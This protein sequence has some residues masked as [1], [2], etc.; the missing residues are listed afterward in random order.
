MK[1]LRVLG[2][3]E[4]IKQKFWQEASGGRLLFRKVSRPYAVL[5][6]LLSPLLGHVDVILFRYLNDRKR[7]ISSF[8]RLVADLAVL[9]SARSR[10]IKVYWM[11]HNVDCESKVF[12]PR[13]SRWRRIILGYFSTNIFVTEDGLIESAIELLPYA[14]DK[15]ISACTFGLIDEV[16]RKPKRKKIVDDNLGCVPIGK[17]H[18]FVSLNN[19]SPKKLREV[20][21]LLELAEKAADFSS[22]HFIAGGDQVTHIKSHQVELYSALLSRQNVTLLPGWISIDVLVDKGLCNAVIKSYDD[23]SLSLGLVRACSLGLP[24]VSE[25]GTFMGGLVGRYDIGVAVG[26]FTSFDFVLAE[27]DRIGKSHEGADRFLKA[28]TWERGAMA[29]ING[30]QEHS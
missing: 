14:R 21:F 5:V 19:W 11:A 15:P 13:L 17:S 12:H 25:E 7:L 26:S 2:F 6:V 16:S 4:D 23:L 27:C 18:Y 1:P 29:L 8:T 10:G 30:G 22:V 9:L 28:N 24:M 20:E 3:R